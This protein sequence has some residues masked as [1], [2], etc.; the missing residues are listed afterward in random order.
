[1]GAETEEAEEEGQLEGRERIRKKGHCTDRGNN[2][3]PTVR[4]EFRA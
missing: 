1:M 2:D 4:V 3:Y